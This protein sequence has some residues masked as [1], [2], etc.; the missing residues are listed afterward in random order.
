[1]AGPA[2]RSLVFDDVPVPDFAD[3]CVVDAAA[4][5]VRVVTAVRLK[6]WRGRL[7]FGPVRLL[8]PVV[9]RAMLRRAAR[10][11]AGGAPPPP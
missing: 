9:V 11:L 6:G 10:G 5:L 8:H 3:V 1:M 7:Y 2:F 4:A